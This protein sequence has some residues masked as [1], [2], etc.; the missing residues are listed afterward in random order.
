VNVFANAQSHCYRI[1]DFRNIG[2]HYD[3]NYHFPE[4]T[5]VGSAS[6]QAIIA[7]GR[8]SEHSLA[9][10][11]RLAFCDL[12]IRQPYE[13]VSLGHAPLLILVRL[14]GNVRLNIGAL[15][16]RWTPASMKK[17]QVCRFASIFSVPNT[18]YVFQIIII[19]II[20]CWANT[21]VFSGAVTQ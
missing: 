14:E 12:C 10:G 19:R 7:E 21:L 18:N 20:V 16:K 1:R 8:I 9:S 13:S 15:E 11:F 4:L 5:A 2:E 17:R 3:I 6:E